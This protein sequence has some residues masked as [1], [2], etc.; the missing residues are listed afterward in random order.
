MGHV[1]EYMQREDAGVTPIVMYAGVPRL[2]KDGHIEVNIVCAKSELTPPST[3]VSSCQWEFDSI[4]SNV[5]VTSR[6]LHGAFVCVSE[7]AV[8]DNSKVSKLPTDFASHMI[9]QCVTAAWK[10]LEEQMGNQPQSLSLQVQFTPLSTHSVVEA[11]VNAIAD[12]I[13][14][15]GKSAIAYMPV[16]SL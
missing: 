13:G 12:R 15:V 11:A 2:P 4:S 3:S 5:I 10:C 16:L 1:V 14:I 8:N 9:E 7:F 6:P